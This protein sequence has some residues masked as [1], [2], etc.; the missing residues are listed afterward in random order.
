MT[1]RRNTPQA[2]RRGMS[3]FE[4]LEIDVVMGSSDECWPWLGP[5]NRWGYGRLTPVGS[6]EILMHRVAWERHNGREIPEGMVVRHSCDNP[7]CC[8]PGHLVLGSPTQ[9]RSDCVE[10]QRHTYGVACKQAVLNPGVVRAAREER[11]S[12]G[13]TYRELADKYGVT[14]VTMRRAVLGLTWKQVDN[15]GLQRLLADYGDAS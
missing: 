11:A 14:E 7:P 3:P 9:N 8:N 12:A 2:I 15:A 10:R 4:R 1:A 5:R 13:S 6:Q